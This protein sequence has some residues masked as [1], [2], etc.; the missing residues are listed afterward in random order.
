MKLISRFTVVSLLLLLLLPA[1]SNLLYSQ[2]KYKPSA[3]RVG[4]DLYGIGRTI[5][6]EDRQKYEINADLALDKYFLV[7]DFGID[8]LQLDDRVI[9]AQSENEQ[10]FSYKNDGY[11]FKLGADVNFMEDDPNNHVIFFG[12]RYARS[13]FSD[14]L[15]LQSKSDVFVLPP[16]ESGNDNIRGRWFELAAGMKVNLW[17]E[18]FVGYTVKYKVFRKI[19]NEGFLT[20]Y[21]MPGYG[22]YEKENRVGFHYQIFWRFP[23]K[24]QPT[25]KDMVEEAIPE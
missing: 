13:F 25:V 18:L 15:T 16:L 23:F 4:T 3:V 9:N 5:F 14:E 22:V 24:N 11:Y 6:G 21:E 17:K 8:N 2:S 7:A 20:P 12:L 10:T 19:N 1:F